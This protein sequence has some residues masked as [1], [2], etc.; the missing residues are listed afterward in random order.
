MEDAL[1]NPKPRYKLSD[2]F[3]NDVAELVKRW[4][5]LNTNA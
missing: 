2:E 4:E 3:Y 1:A 5:I